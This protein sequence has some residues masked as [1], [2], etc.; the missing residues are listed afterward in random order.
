MIS[1][2]FAVFDST[3]ADTRVIMSTVPY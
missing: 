1:Y 3:G 2:N